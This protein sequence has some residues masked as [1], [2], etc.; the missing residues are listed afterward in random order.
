MLVVAGDKDQHQRTM[1]LNNFKNGQVPVMIATD[2]A[3]RGLDVK[4][5][6][7]VVNYDFPGNVEDYVSHN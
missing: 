3:A 4:L 5:I 6:K 7:V 2:V 1:T